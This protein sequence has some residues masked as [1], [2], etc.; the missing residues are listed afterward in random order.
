[1][2]FVLQWGFVKDPVIASPTWTAFEYAKVILKKKIFIFKAQKIL[3]CILVCIFYPCG[4]LKQ[5]IVA[6]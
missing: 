5:K 6:L 1:M 3:D 4:I 2:A